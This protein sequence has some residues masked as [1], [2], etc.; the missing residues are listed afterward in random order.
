MRRQLLPAIVSVAA[1][2]LACGG[3]TM[4]RMRVAQYPPDFHYI[5]KGEIQTRMGELAKD[6]VALD[7]L[8]SAEGGPGTD[9]RDQVLTILRR[10]RIVAGQLKK[11]GTRSSHPRIDE[12]APRLV[13][14]IERAI[15][16]VRMQTPPTYY[17]AGRVVGTCTYCHESRI[18]RA[19][20]AKP[21]G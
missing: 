16:E 10:M 11:A 8:L 5:T 7:A 17:E 13:T 20:H 4:G 15:A 9:E 21:P 12:G 6:V 19:A 2:S 3:D 18:D 14:D 1:L